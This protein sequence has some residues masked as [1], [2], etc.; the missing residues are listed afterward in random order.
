MVLCLVDYVPRLFKQQNQ[1]TGANH[2]SFFWWINGIEKFFFEVK[3]KKPD[4]K[5]GQN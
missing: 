1:V 3:I 4:K 5:K 2:T